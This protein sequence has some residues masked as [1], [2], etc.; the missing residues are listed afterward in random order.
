MYYLKAI[1]STI[2]FSFL[3]SSS[4]LAQGTEKTDFFQN[5]G[6]FYV[7]IAV[8]GIIFIGLITILVWL[9]R[10]LSKLEKETNDI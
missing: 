10:R 2:F 9:E 3:I 1:S 8:L 5:A 7:V 4:M 6:K